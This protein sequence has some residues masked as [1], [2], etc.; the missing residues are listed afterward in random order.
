[1][2]AASQTHGRWLKKNETNTFAIVH[3]PFL[4]SAHLFQTET[5]EATLV[6]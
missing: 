3:Q 4:V 2:E 1:M 5:P 6:L